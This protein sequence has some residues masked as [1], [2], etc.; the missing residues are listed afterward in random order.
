M[1]K[2]SPAYKDLIESPIILPPPPPQ[3]M[4]KRQ[5][6]WMSTCS[7][8]KGHAPKIGKG[9]RRLVEGRWRWEKLHFF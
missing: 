9:E 3:W 1:R 2:I 5:W 8:V 6:D 7:G 4:Q